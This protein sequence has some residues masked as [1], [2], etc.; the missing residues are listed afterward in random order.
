MIR[1][2]VSVPAESLQPEPDVRLVN[3]ESPY[4]IVSPFHGDEFALLLVTCTT[5][6]KD[7][8]LRIADEIESSGASYVCC[9][10]VD[11]ELWHDSVDWANIEKYP[12]GDV[13]DEALILTTWHSNESL[14]EAA[15]H[16]LNCGVTS[17][18]IPAKRFLAVVL[19]GDEETIGRLRVLGR[20]RGELPG[21]AEQQ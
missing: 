16:W 17:D 14:D 8:R 12:E 19:D 7:D 15:W 10:G 18:L 2:D 3:L 1:Y 21:R 13:P 11:C 6:G 5:I 20:H 9:W 4:P